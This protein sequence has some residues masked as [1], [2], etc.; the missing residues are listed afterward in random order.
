VIAALCRQLW[1]IAVV[2]EGIGMRARDHVNGA[3]VS[4]VATARPAARH[5]LLAAE[6]ETSASA[7]AR[8][9]VNVDFVNEHR[10]W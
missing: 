4:A 8:R 1:M 7:V 10:I 9:N 5:E 6:G 2:D 3:A